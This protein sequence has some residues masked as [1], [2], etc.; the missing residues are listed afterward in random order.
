MVKERIKHVVRITPSEVKNFV[1]EAESC[2]FDIDVSLGS[3]VVDAKSILGILALNLQKNLTVSYYGE[4]E[5]FEEY[6]ATI[7]VK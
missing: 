2:N 6:L 5:K 3:I 1:H 7:E 4:N